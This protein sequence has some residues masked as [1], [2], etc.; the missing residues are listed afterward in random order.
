[1]HVPLLAIRREISLTIPVTSRTKGVG[2]HVH[3]TPITCNSI[4][5]STTSIPRYW[6]DFDPFRAYFTRAGFALSLDTSKPSPLLT[7]LPQGTRGPLAPTIATN[8]LLGPRRRSH[9]RLTKLSTTSIYETYR[10]PT[11]AGRRRN[12]K[13]PSC[14]RLPKGNCAW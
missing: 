10:V 6:T 9:S 4:A 3:T 8:I 13:D 7:R 5:A 11:H 12:V 14:I 2:Y 1:M